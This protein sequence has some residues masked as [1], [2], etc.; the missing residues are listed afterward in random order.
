MTRFCCRILWISLL[1]A[2]AA[3]CSGQPA[4]PS[5]NGGGA[6]NGGGAGD[7]ATDPTSLFTLNCAQPERGKPTLRLLTR[8]EFTRTIED[9]FPELSGSWS[10]TLPNAA[11]SRY[12]FDND[13]SGVVGPQLA[14]ALLDTASSVA[15][16]VTGPALATLLPCSASTPDRACAERFIVQYGR[17]LFRRPVTPAER[18]RYLAFFDRHSAQSDFQQA[19][20]WITVGLIQSPSAVYRS[21]IGSVAG[22]SRTLDAH[23]LAT[24]LAYTYS[25]TTPSDALL[26]QADTGSID[27]LGT[28]QTLLASA[29]GKAT[30]QRFFASYL[31][32]PRVTSVERSNIPQWGAVRG[33][34]L[35]ETRSFIEQVVL[36][37]P[38]GLRELLTTDTTNPSQALAAYYGFPEPPFDGATVQ[39][40]RGRGIGLLAQGSILATRA[41]P[42]GSSPTQRG[43][44]V[45]SR[46]LCRT[47]PTP[48]ANVPG[49]SSPKPGRATTRQRYEAEHA[50]NPPCSSCHQLFDPIGFGFER[51]DE[52]GR[53]RE[54]DDGLAI[55]TSSSV[56]TSTG[57][58][59]FSFQDEEELAR[60]L[61]DRADVY[62]C[63]AAFLATYAFGSAEA[64][65]G[66]SRLAEFQ[67]GDLGIADYYATLAAEPHFSSRELR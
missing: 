18:A 14:Q 36:T 53:Y 15:R 45:Y 5:G 21:E 1:S 41:Q 2:G 46:L 49:I 42:N 16:A 8:S 9:I 22:D 3:S 54:T 52:G 44:L 32:Y 67:S 17:R 24:E 28:A 26:A 37:H 43:L 66:A 61:A 59:L 55:D 31:D 39:R 48:P 19:I 10:S 29:P 11:V 20:K 50:R 25:G 6:S 65:L 51:F 58:P 34:M 64:C 4:L 56:P 38:G 27:A 60:G 35:A 62:Q 23:E 57:A 47:K 13:A 40:P 7:G 12:G 33:P 63:F 30:L